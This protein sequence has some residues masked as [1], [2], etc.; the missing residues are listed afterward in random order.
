[1]VGYVWGVAINGA[2]AYLEYG[3]KLELAQHGRLR[4][5]NLGDEDLGVDVVVMVGVEGVKVAVQVLQREQADVR[6]RLAEV[7]VARCR[8]AETALPVTDEWVRRRLGDV[9][10]QTG[11][12]QRQVAMRLLETVRLVVMSTI[13]VVHLRTQCRNPDNI[14][15]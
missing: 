8:D 3:G 4:T 12:E 9:R 14:K 7:C 2:L 15:H 11:A 5:V 6:R 1:M 10:P 13:L